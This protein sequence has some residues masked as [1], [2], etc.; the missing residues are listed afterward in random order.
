MT[1]RANN[2]VE[3][4]ALVIEA[5]QPLDS[6]ER[7]RILSTVATFFRTDV[8]TQGIESGAGLARLAPASTAAPRFSQDR[9]P[10]PKEFLHLK[11]PQTDV[12]RVVCLAYYLAHYRDTPFFS[13]VDLSALNT[14]AA[15]HKFSNA[16][17]A[18]GNALKAGYL[19]AGTKREKQLSAPGERYV[20]A[21]P[22]R[23]AAKE[24]MQGMR[25]RRRRATNK[26]AKARS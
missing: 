16:A 5:L 17:F 14:E 4:L 7:A 6:T 9:T 13:T 26:P 24:A 3:V 23:V 12:E 8:G 25:P 1:T 10:S 18:V 22:D 19:V 2:E 21:L 11:R 20:E 15:Q